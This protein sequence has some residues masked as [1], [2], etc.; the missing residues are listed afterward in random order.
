MV[1]L[2]SSSPMNRAGISHTS[3]Q[4]ETVSAMKTKLFSK[5]APRPPVPQCTTTRQSR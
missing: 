5:T 3:C 1:M 4:R 2:I